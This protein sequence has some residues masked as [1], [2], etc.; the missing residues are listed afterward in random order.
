[1]QFITLHN[2]IFL[3][4][5]WAFVFEFYNFN[6]VASQILKQSLMRNQDEEIILLVKSQDEQIILHDTYM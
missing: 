2:T 4:H 3:V 6:K 1:M 5:R